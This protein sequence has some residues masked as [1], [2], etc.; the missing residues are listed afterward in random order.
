VGKASTFTGVLNITSSTIVGNVGFFSQPAPTYIPAT[1]TLTTA[2][3]FT[4]VLLVGNSAAGT[5]IG[6]TLPTGTLMDTGVTA[7]LG[8]ITLSN[9]YAFDWYVINTS[10]VAGGLVTLAAG[11]GHTY[12]G[13]GTIYSSIAAS[14]NAGHF[15]T[16]KTAANTFV[17]YRIG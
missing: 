1:A 2:N 11:T 3:L 4:S 15:R 14:P 8:G 17:T 16:T 6:L 5:T 7:L 9:Q 10:T 13:S 12:I